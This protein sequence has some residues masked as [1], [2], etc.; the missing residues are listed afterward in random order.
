MVT[1]ADYLTMD[2]RSR[3]GPRGINLRGVGVIRILL[4]VIG[5]AL[6][7]VGLVPVDVSVLFHNTFSITALVGFAALLVLV[8]T[9][10]RGLPKGFVITTLVVI[11]LVVAAVA[12]FVTG[13]YN[14]TALEL[15]AVLVIF[16]WL[17]LFARNA[18]GGA[19]D[20]WAPEPA[21]VERV[22]RR[23]IGAVLVGALAVGAFLAGRISRR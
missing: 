8:P 3:P 13:Y 1:L 19:D 5:A 21:A 23:R 14:L 16:A 20:A 6:T 17:I 12:L 15:V 10:L 7:G 18:T 22:Q 4:L 11:G 2:L 9:L